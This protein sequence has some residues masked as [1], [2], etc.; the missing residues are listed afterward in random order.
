MN[1]SKAIRPMLTKKPFIFVVAV[2]LL[3]GLFDQ[4]HAQS[5]AD[6]GASVATAAG[7]MIVSGT[8]DEIQR[9]AERYGLTLAQELNQG[10][11]LVG[12]PEQLE[13][14][15][16]DSEVEH[17]SPDA[18]VES[19]MAVGTTSIGADQVWEGAGSFGRIAG[20]GIGVAIVDSGISAHPDLGYRVVATV[21]FAE[22]NGDG[23]DLYGHGT[24]VAGLVAG[25]APDAHLINVRV[26][27][28]EGWGHASE[29]IAGIDYVVEHMNEF[30]IRGDT[31]NAS[32]R[33]RDGRLNKL[34]ERRRLHT[35]RSSYL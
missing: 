22:P 7:R 14:L 27:N 31:L 8:Q 32:Q 19:S 17:I 20:A 26:L 13:A 30:S 34:E 1:E 6:I 2:L 9:L 5:G 12:T 24:H 11:A 3:S 10:G 33:A 23:R 21:D 18:I 28:D 16:R 25:V 29:V 15:S 35:S 4:A